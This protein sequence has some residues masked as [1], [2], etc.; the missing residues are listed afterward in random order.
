MTA[1]SLT[2]AGFVRDLSLDRIPGAVLDKAKLHMLDVLGIALS[3]AGRDYGQA[4][5]QAAQ[6]LGSGDACTV[7]GF[8][9]RMPAASA[10]LV[11]GTLIHGLDYDD[12]HIEGIV[13]SGTTVVPTALAVGEEIGADGA[14]LLAAMVAGYEIVTRLGIAAQGNLHPRGFH[15]TAIYGALSSSQIAGRLYGMSAENMASGMGLAGTMASGLLEIETSW[16]K[17]LNPGWAAHAG[18]TAALLARQGFLGPTGILEGEHGLYASHL[19]G[20]SYQ[21]EALT[22]GL[23]ETWETLNIGLKPYP[24]CHFLHASLDCSR[25]LREQ[26]GFD[27]NDIEEITCLISEPLMGLLREEFFRPTTEYGAQFSVPFTVA[28]MLAHG[29]VDLSSFRSERLTDPAL[30][31]LIDKTRIEP[32][33]L[34]DYPKNFPGQVTV[35]LKNGQ[36]FEHREGVNRGTPHNPLSYEEVV[37]KFQENAADAGRE[38][39]GQALLTQIERFEKIADVREFMKILAG[40]QA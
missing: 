39:T 32:D 3:S 7:I 29:A 9:G 38:E 31:A 20:G 14:S 26:P 22:E 1:I 34:S 30:N 36:V 13:H 5:Y 11:N 35:K 4:V 12:T 18:I 21:L 19:Y 25:I 16:L 17:R 37:R 6:A 15:P 40:G 24:C 28:T 10:A 27:A 33:P 2:L 8:P 23:G